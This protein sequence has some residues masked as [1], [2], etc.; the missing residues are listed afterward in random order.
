MLRHEPLKAIDGLNAAAPFELG[1][2][3]AMNSVSFVAALYPVYVRGQAYLEAQQGA[4]AAAEFRKIVAHR[5]IVGPDPIGRHLADPKGY[6]PTSGSTNL[7]A[8]WGGVDGNMR[9]RRVV[10]AFHR[11]IR[12]RM[13]FEPGR[14]TPG[15]DHA[16]PMPR[17]EYQRGVEQW[18]RQPV[19]APARQRL[20][21][22]EPVPKARH[23]C[24]VELQRL[25]ARPLPRRQ[26]NIGS[27]ADAV[28]HRRHL[29]LGSRTRAHREQD[30]QQAAH[31]EN[32]AY[33]LR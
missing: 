11:R 1:L 5:G 30:H 8:V 31:V 25:I 4:A 26:I 9:H 33:H 32:S 29:G 15:H 27:Q 19:H 16:D 6:S 7:D 2:A 17:V 14:V 12:I 23:V 20:R 24:L 3:N 28:A 22:V 10:V 18:N 13:R 21:L